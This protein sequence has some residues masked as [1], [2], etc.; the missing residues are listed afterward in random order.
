MKRVRFAVGVACVAVAAVLFVLRV[1][2]AA[3]SLNHA[4]GADAR[5]SSPL[6]RELVTGDILD[7]PYELQAAALQYVPAGATYQLQLAAPGPGALSSYGIQPFVY[8]VFEPWMRYLL[9]PSKEVGGDHPQYVICWGCD[10][11]PWDRRTDWLW[12]NGQGALIG[13]VRN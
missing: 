12:R 13:R 3:R 7:I 11:G 2:H 4:A 6:Y 8:D 1:P 5:Y 9:L 10:T